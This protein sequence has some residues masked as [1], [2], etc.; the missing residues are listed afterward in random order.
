MN[1]S[2]LQASIFASSLI[3]F[4]IWIPF[5]QLISEERLNSFSDFLTA[6]IIIGLVSLILFI[7]FWLMHFH[8]ESKQSNMIPS[9]KY[10]W[11]FLK[12]A[13]I[14]FS[15]LT[16]FTSSFFIGFK[17]RRSEYSEAYKSVQD[18]YDCATQISEDSGELNRLYRLANESKNQKFIQDTND[19]LTKIKSIN[20]CESKL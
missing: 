8:I 20:I 16:L 17:D 6:F 1:E 7:S 13:L 3:T 19:L 15:A 10:T 2:K 12:P 4:T 18:I 9:L 5:A 14:I 11:F